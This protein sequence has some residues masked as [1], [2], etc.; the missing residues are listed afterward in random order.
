MLKQEE[1][2][3]LRGEEEKK[4]EEEILSSSSWNLLSVK[5]PY[6]SSL[7]FNFLVSSGSYRFLAISSRGLA[8]FYSSLFIEL[9]EAAE[10]K[11]E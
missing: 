10:S 6:F 11:G 3:R 2:A 4:D 7:T 5:F 9:Q 8:L 1:N